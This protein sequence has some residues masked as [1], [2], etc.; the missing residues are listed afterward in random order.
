MAAMTVTRVAGN[1]KVT[2]APAAVASS[3]TLTASDIGTNGVLLR[4]N[5]GGGA[6]IN[7]TVSDPGSTGVGNAGTPAAQ[8]VANGTAGWFRI[9]PGNVNISTG[10]ATVSYSATTSVTYEAMPL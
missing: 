4:V 8:A 9:L 6:P 10:L 3:D 2:S 1:T 5:N 7:V